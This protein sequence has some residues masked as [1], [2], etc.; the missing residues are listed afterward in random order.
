MRALL[1]SDIH[2]NLPAFEAVLAA[3]PSHDAVWNLSDVVGYGPNP[4]E[5]IVLAR[6]L[7]G[8]VVR[9][10]H[11]RACAGIMP[12]GKFCD[13]SSLA[14]SAVRWTQSVLTKENAEW[15]AK[16]RRGP[17]WQHRRSCTLCSLARVGYGLQMLGRRTGRNGYT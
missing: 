16:L 1:I 9:G 10:N 3:A 6:N 17:F 14:A 2:G 7:G 11:D 4:N 13:F 8:I 12:Y 5:V 15:L